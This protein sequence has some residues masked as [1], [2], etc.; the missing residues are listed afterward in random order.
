MS[1]RALNRPVAAPAL[2]AAALLAAVVSLALADR[3]GP[4]PVAVRGHSF[5]VTLSDYAITPQTLSVPGGEVRIVVRNSGILTHNLTLE[6]EQDNANGE[7][8]V[9]AST[10]GVAPGGTAAIA[11]LS[12]GAGRYRMVS[13]LAN[14]A[15]LGMT[16]T[17][18]VR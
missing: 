18:L 13:T 11:T 15:D 9:I 5:E 16:G 3:G 2:L 10:H 8:R 4:A 6:Y 17:L 1:I 12:L 7:P 14:Q